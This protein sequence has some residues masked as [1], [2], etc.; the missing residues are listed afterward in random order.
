MTVQRNDIQGLRAIAVIAV[1]L[2]HL[3][4]EWLPGGFIGVDVFLVISG[5]LIT[6]IILKNKQLGQFSFKQFYINRFKRIAPAYYAMLAIVSMLMAILLITPD[7]DFYKQSLYSALYFAS[8]QYFAGF[9]DYFAPASHEQALLHT[10]S[11]AVEM[12]FYLLLPV[13]VIFLPKRYLNFVFWILL[14]SISLYVTW[15]LRE[16]LNSQGLYFSLVAR[17]SEFLLGAVIASSSMGSHWRANQTN[18]LSLLGAVVLVCSF[19]FID[20]TT[21]FPGLI[22]LI[23]CLGCAL[24]IISARGRVN[25]VLSSSAMVWIGGLSYSIYLW[26]WPILA[27]FRY[28][29]GAYQLS[30]LNSVVF[31]FLTLGI[32]Y[33]SWRWIE[34]PFRQKNNR[35]L[36]IKF[37]ILLSVLISVIIFMPIINA[38]LVAPLPIEMTRYAD[39]QKICHGK[40]VDECLQGDLQSTNEILVIGDS[41]AAQ[42]NHTFSILGKELGFKARIITGSSCVTI[43]EFDVKRIPRWAQQACEKQIQEAKYYLDN[44]SVIVL[45][46]MWQ[47]HMPSAEFVGALESFLK[48]YTKE[49]KEIIVLSQIPMF[50]SNM[51]RV[52]RFEQ[53]GIVPQLQDNKEWKLANKQVQDLVK[54]FP[55]VRYLDTSSNEFFDNAPFYKKQLIY[56]DK[57]HFN[58]F[59]ASSYSIEIKPVLQDMKNIK[60]KETVPKN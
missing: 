51:A 48:T 23:P 40:I 19:V 49:D 8:N 13:I 14:A 27:T 25:T 10:W 32:S 1:V 11:L 24:I 46:A 6:S 42:L 16:P 35:K 53:L 39:N 3:N 31:L 47:F 12:Q 34:S 29:T 26:H 5:Y 30:L 17:I 56:Y 33:V 58:E 7:L 9:G 37:A 44:A 18:L 21:L 4:K 15:E 43:P 52:A 57:H 45:A 36:I 22:A 28:F 2:F 60:L 50:E 59:G 55:S 38:K 41:H 54:K 20:E